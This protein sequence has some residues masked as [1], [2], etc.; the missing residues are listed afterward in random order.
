[1]ATFFYYLIGQKKLNSFYKN[2]DSGGY[3]LVE[4]HAQW[5]VSKYISKMQE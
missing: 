5:H 2:T 1:M 4:L 3:K